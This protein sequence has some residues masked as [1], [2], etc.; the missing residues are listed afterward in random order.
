MQL[1]INEE[2][3]AVQTQ[4]NELRIE[5][6]RSLSNPNGYAVT[7]RLHLKIKQ[8]ELY[9][10]T[11]EGNFQSHVFPDKTEV[12]YYN[13]RCKHIEDIPPLL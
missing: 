1:T 11:L 5:I 8:L 4:L 2:I 9:L 7:K 3:T 6:N 10:K 12:G 13:R